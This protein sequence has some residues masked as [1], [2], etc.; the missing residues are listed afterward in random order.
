[1]DFL[2][3]L[4]NSQRAKRPRVSCGQRLL[5]G[6][7]HGL[8]RAN[9]LPTPP[10]LRQSLSPVSINR[11]CHSFRNSE[12]E[13]LV[14]RVYLSSSGRWGVSSFSFLSFFFSFQILFFFSFSFFCF[15][16]LRHKRTRPVSRHWFPADC[17][18]GIA[19]L[20]LKLR[21]AL[22]RAFLFI[23]TYKDRS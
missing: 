8:T 2:Q 23:G 16:F 14:L 22:G 21:A 13:C 20:Y 4:I 6:A 17:N 19:F 3:R 7:R 18:R 11:T 5:S 10:R 15:F 9:F 1:M 12:E